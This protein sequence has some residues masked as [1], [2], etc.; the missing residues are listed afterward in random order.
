[1]VLEGRQREI[2]GHVSPERVRTQGGLGTF[3]GCIQNRQGR[4]KVEKGGQWGARRRP[5]P[6]SPGFLLKVKGDWTVVGICGRGLM[7]LHA[8]SISGLGEGLE[9]EEGLVCCCHSHQ[10]LTASRYFLDC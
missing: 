5:W 8:G 2:L 4:W 6:W 10:S 9:G 1:M 3:L 7:K